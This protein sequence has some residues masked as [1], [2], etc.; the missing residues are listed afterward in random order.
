M[1]L[2]DKPRGFHH[3]YPIFR[4]GVIRTV[5][6]LRPMYRGTTSLTKTRWIHMNR[7]IIYISLALL[8]LSESQHETT[9]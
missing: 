4:P 7:F 1:I 9:I 8:E 5:P 6:K 2:V 3:C